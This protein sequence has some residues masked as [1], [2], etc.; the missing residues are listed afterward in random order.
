MHFAVRRPPCSFVLLSSNDAYKVKRI[1]FF[2]SEIVMANPS[3]RILPLRALARQF[4]EIMDFD[5]GGP[6]R[7]FG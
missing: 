1:W 5:Q 4:E 3:R 6:S 7:F 2:C